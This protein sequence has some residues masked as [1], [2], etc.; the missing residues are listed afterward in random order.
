M[1]TLE[2]NAAPAE[3]SGEGVRTPEKAVRW[4]IPL[5]LLACVLLAF[6]DKISIA[7]LF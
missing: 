2:T 7:A 6:F 4:A 1:T 3:A 5:S